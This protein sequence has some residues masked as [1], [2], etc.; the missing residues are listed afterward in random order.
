MSQSN[1]IGSRTT[2]QSTL[3]NAVRAANT[4]PFSQGARD[5]MLEMWD[6]DETCQA[7][8]VIEQGITL[9]INDS[10]VC[11][12]AEYIDDGGYTVFHFKQDR[13]TFKIEVK[14][15]GHVSIVSNVTITS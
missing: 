2:S 5:H 13:R 15:E 1:G 8:T 3:V 7:A 4:A 9:T 12:G 14:D 10:L 11:T 6:G